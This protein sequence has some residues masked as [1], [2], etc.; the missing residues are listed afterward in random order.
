M[1]PHFSHGQSEISTWV[2]ICKWENAPHICLYV[3]FPHSGPLFLNSLSIYHATLSQLQL[4]PEA[5]PEAPSSSQK[6]ER[7][8]PSHA[9]WCHAGVHPQFVFPTFFRFF[10]N[11]SKFS[12]GWERIQPRIGENSRELE[13]MWFFIFSPK[14]YYI[15]IFLHTYGNS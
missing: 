4:Q 6:A 2:C 3:L 10:Q 11:L 7:R 8:H 12:P 5:G 15:G 9:S 14:K 1:N 13:R